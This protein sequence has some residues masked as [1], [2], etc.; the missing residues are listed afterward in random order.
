MANHRLSG[1][2]Q[3]LLA[4]ALRHQEEAGGRPV[5]ASAAELAAINLAGGFEERILCRAAAIAGDNGLDLALLRFQRHRRYAFL[6]ILALGLC[7]GGGAAHGVLQPDRA[8]LLNFYWAFVALLGFNALMLTLWA[9]ALVFQPRT[10][11]STPLTA[12]LQGALRLLPAAGTSPA[13]AGAVVAA[14]TQ[15]LARGGL[16][17]WGISTLIHGFWSAALAGM[18][19]V[20]LLLFSA[21]QY[22]LVWETTILSEPVFRAATLALAVVPAKIG[23]S[24]PD[25]ALIAA[26]RRGD[27]PPPPA[28][29]SAWSGLLIGSL[30]VYGLVPRLLLAALSLLLFRRAQRAY[31]LDLESPGYARLRVQLLPA[32]RPLGILDPDPGLAVLD[33]RRA[34]R[35]QLRAADA[36]VAFLGIELDPPVIGWPPP[37]ARD[38]WDLG[39]VRDRDGYLAAVEAV[40]Q[41]Q[42]TPFTMVLVASLLSSPD[43][44]IG[45]LL[46]QLRDAQHGPTVLLL[47]QSGRAARRLGEGERGGLSTRISDWRALAAQAGIPAGSVHVLDLD[48]AEAVRAYHFTDDDVPA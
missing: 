47:T 40:H 16:G 26:S 14:W 25:E 36:P 27:T 7:I 31:R 42:N 38:T 39:R 11:P 32:S 10:P 48:D 46:R 35:E 24:T 5:G 33:E 3:R 9:L 41:R 34:C 23:F 28:G 44:G 4:E 20:S 2:E 8:G 13:N 22:D 17:R 29:R 1:F 12:L 18:L 6:L 19:A 45:R 43:R 21:R 15:T 30:L 37:L